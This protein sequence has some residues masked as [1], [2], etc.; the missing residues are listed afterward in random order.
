MKKASLFSLALFAIAFQ[1]C[2]AQGNSSNLT[3]QGMVSDQS[4]KREAR[5]LLALSTSDYPVTP[6][7]VLSLSFLKIATPDTINCVIG[8]NYELNLGLFGLV[9]A[10]G[11][12]FRELKT[13]VEKK[14][15]DA[16]KDSNPSLLIRSTGSFQVKL[17]GE[18]PAATVVD[19]W[20][21]TRLSEIVQANKS[22]HASIRKVRVISASG[23]SKVFDLFRFSRYADYTQNPYV[24]PGDRV[25]FENAGRLVSIGGEVYRPDTYELVDGDGLKEC[26]SDYAMGLLPTAQADHAYLSK[27]GSV[28]DKDG[29]IYFFDASQVSSSS[30]T[31]LE[32]FDGDKIIVPTRESFLPVVY[33]EGA[34]NAGETTVKAENGVSVASAPPQT[35]VVRRLYKPGDMLGR[36]LR[37][38]APQ[39]QPDADLHRAFLV[40][41]NRPEILPV[42]VEKL[43]YAYDAKSDIPLEAEDRIVIPRGTLDVFLS[44]EVTKSTWIN[45][46]NL[47]RLSITIAPYLTKYSSI[48]DIIVQGRTGGIQHYDLFKAERLGDISQDPYI[49]P[50]DAIVVSKLKRSVGITGEVKRPGVYQLLDGENLKDL[51][52]F[53]AGDFTVLANTQRITIVSEISASENL[54]KMAFLDYN[55]DL[56]YCPKDADSIVVASMKDLLPAVYFEGAIQANQANQANQ[57]IKDIST[58]QTSQKVTYPFVPGESLAHAVQTLREQFSAV[59]DLANAYILRSSQK[60]PVNINRFLSDKDY[61]NDMPLEKD[62]IIIIPFRQFFVSVSG[63]VRIPGRYPYIADRSWEYYIGLAG[64]FNDD[65]N[66]NEALKIVDV[67]GHT[68]TKSDPI[69]PEDTLTAQSNSFFFYLGRVASIV[70]VLASALTAWIYVQSLVK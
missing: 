26:L 9:D 32:I 27:K 16:Y 39:F 55:K 38:I 68:K 69:E 40:R 54:G 70:S 22:S 47:P 8:S 19:A 51:V 66:A 12:T 65:V 11:K 53:Y 29:G 60:I 46:T 17:E 13:L 64:G 14:V 45:S 67:K 21:L 52:S 57:N 10:R 5:A 6:G 50:G 37:D 49:L 25:V 20:G 34:V 23:Q 61:S 63:A 24:R 33:F 28:V 43:L 44:G 18:I 31:N 7:D 30:N 58:L 1:L 4:D 62:D 2:P 48:R 35:T 15:G 3:N 59:S 56:G 42:D 36:M 41:K